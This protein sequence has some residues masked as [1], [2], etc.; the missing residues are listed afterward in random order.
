[1]KIV[2]LEV[3]AIKIQELRNEGKKVSH[4]HGCFDLMHPG[5]IKYFQVSKKWEMCLL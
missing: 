1:M 3:L 4:C 2:D 5:H